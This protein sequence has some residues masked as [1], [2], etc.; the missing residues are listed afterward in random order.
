MAVSERVLKR[1]DEAMDMFRE[2]FPEPAFEV[3][4]RSPRRKGGDREFLLNQAGKNIAGIHVK[5][6]SYKMYLADNLV[7]ES[8]WEYDRLHGGQF[9]EFLNIED[10]ISEI[11]NTMQSVKN[12]E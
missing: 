1:R 10:C 2:A 8:E 12:R 4:V 3:R 7:V 9:I 6:D 11:K 5:R